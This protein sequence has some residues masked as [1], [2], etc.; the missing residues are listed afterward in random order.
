MQGSLILDLDPHS[1]GIGWG[2]NSSIFFYRSY[3][4]PD[5][6]KL[7][8]RLKM[9]LKDFS[10]KSNNIK[11]ILLRFDISRFFK[12]SFTEQK[13]KIGY[14]YTSRSIPNQVQILRAVQDSNIQIEL[15]FL[16]FENQKTLNSQIEKKLS[17][18]DKKGIRHI[19]VSSY[20]SLLQTGIDEH[21]IDIC[22]QL[23]NSHFTYQKI[24]NFISSNTA[25]RENTLLLNCIFRD[26]TREIIRNIKESLQKCGLS[27]PVLYFISTGSLTDEETV[28]NNPFLTWQSA[29]AAELKGASVSS[30][31][32]NAI[33]FL[34]DGNRFQIGLVN[35]YQ[36]ATT[37]ELNY[38]K[39]IQL[40][41][42]YPALMSFDK[43][44]SEKNLI[45]SISR[46]NPCIGYIPLLN[47]CKKE[48]PLHKLNYPIVPIHDEKKARL[49]GI[50]N[51]S[52]QLAYSEVLF[53]L[54]KDSKKEKI[55][56][57]VNSVRTKMNERSI[58]VSQFK[59]NINEIHPKYLKNECR[60]VTVEIESELD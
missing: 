35:D 54:S 7:D 44:P 42:N 49:F 16:D 17:E 43:V 51:S 52:F 37:Y 56:Q 40:C 30:H 22:Q 13:T 10:L 60:I 32:P 20:Y 6:T 39:G 59:Y 27:I 26:K 21:V 46:L 2:K 50:V 5:I 48:L 55:K 8:F 33:G 36:L 1:L 14:F 47:I 31:T 18:F 45:A 4:F 12:E 11:H 24:D 3:P 34:L 19:A 57:F 58:S 29:Q 28:V 23:T 25:L 41:G 9:F 53:D 38:Y 15:C